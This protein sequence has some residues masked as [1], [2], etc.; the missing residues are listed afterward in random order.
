M[1]CHRQAGE[2]RSLRSE[3]RQEWSGFLVVVW[4]CFAWV[5]RGSDGLYSAAHTIG[6]RPYKFKRECRTKVRHHSMRWNVRFSARRISRRL[7]GHDRIVLDE[8]Y[9]VPSRAKR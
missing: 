6:G 4:P 5:T 2:R 3:N 1:P 7:E 9:P 8:K